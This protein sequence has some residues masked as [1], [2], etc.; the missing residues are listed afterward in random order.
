MSVSVLIKK[1][2]MTLLVKEANSPSIAVMARVVI[3][4][5]EKKEETARDDVVTFCRY[6]SPL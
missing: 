5:A 4:L 2:D 3:E 1:V 6:Q